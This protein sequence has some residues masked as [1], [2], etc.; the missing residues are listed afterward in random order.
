[1]LGPIEHTMHTNHLALVVEYLVSHNPF[2]T[3]SRQERE[4]GIEVKL[5]IVMQT[6]TVIRSIVLYAAIVKIPSKS[7]KHD[8][9]AKAQ[10]HP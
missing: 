3:Q 9:I 10:T 2:Q 1:M 7:L 8:P 4:G 5:K 6:P